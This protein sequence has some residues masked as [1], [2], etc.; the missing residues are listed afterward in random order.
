MSR[1]AKN[2]VRFASSSAASAAMP[3]YA[4]CP[5]VSTW[6]L[7]LTGQRVVHGELPGRRHGRVEEGGRDQGGQRQPGGRR[8]RVEVAEDLRDPGVL[9]VVRPDRLAAAR[10]GQGQAQRVVAEGGDRELGSAEAVVPGQREGPEPAAEALAQVAEAGAAGP[11]GRLQLR[12]EG[13][14][15]GGGAPEVGHAVPDD[16]RRTGFDA[17]QDVR[18]GHVRDAV[19]PAP[20]PHAPDARQEH[21]GPGQRRRQVAAGLLASAVAVPDDES[22]PDGPL[23]G[24]GEPA[25]EPDAA[26]GGVGHAVDPQAV[27]LLLHRAEDR[28]RVDGAGAGVPAAPEGVEAVGGGRGGDAQQGVRRVVPVGR[29]EREVVGEGDG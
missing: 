27:A 5:A 23:G 17:V 22:V 2:R 15:G 8:R 3:R 4:K 11:A 19:H 7:T 1:S 21:G 16:V 13:R 9:A 25:A 20:L 26:H 14:E 28:P 12:D 10:A 18:V 29:V 24:Q 6:R